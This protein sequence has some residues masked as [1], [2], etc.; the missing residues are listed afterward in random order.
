MIALAEDH[1]PPSSLVQLW[2]C[3]RFVTLATLLPL[4][5]FWY[6]G[7]SLPWLSRVI[8]SL[9]L[10]ALVLAHSYILWV[11]PQSLS[12]E[13]LFYDLSVHGL[14]RNYCIPSQ[15]ILAVEY[16][17][18]EQLRYWRGVSIHRYHMGRAYSPGQGW[19]AVAA[20]SRRGTG[21]MLRYRH[22]SG[23]QQLVLSPKEPEVLRCVLEQLL[24][25]H[26]ERMLR[27]QP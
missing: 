19:V 9:F 5:D 6:S 22:Y 17:Q 2:R 27:G 16:V 12:Y 13:L 18:L 24:H 14:M 11:G 26:H 4:I 3:V 1:D 8:A 20:S 25:E 23:L 15:H 21:L 7:A 10:L